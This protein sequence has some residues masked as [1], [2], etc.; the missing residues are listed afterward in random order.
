[1]WGKTTNELNILELKKEM[2]LWYKDTKEK[3]R[4]QGKLSVERIR[5]KGGWPKLKAKA[6]AT[7]NLSKFALHLALKYKRERPLKEAAE[8]SRM[9]A[10]AQLLVRFYEI[11]DA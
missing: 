11:L 9:I 5:T 4:V 8:D 2:D 10:V 1:M 3:S 7:R 6:A